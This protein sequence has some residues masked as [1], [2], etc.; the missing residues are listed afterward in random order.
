MLS[1]TTTRS[2]CS[3]TTPP[4]ASGPMPVYRNGLMPPAA[5]PSRHAHDLRNSVRRPQACDMTTLAPR[6]RVRA[7]DGGRLTAECLDCGQELLL[8]PG[9]DMIAA[10]ATLDE[11]HPPR[12]HRPRTSAAP[13]GWLVPLSAFGAWSQQLPGGSRARRT[14]PAAVNP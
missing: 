3:A 5:R 4:T 9:A 7:G 1:S 12:A 10:L 11:A 8:A 13:G 14:R 2:G 6:P